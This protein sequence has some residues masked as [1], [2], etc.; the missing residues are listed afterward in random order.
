MF[1]PLVDVFDQSALVVVHVNSGRDVHGRN[2]HHAFLDLALAHDFF[3]LRRN[4]HVGAMRLGMKLQILCQCLHF[5]KLR[6]VTL[7]FSAAPQPRCHSQSNPRSVPSPYTLP[8]PSPSWGILS[9]SRLAP[10]ARALKSSAEAENREPGL[11][12][13]L[14]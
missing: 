13:W 9:G 2:Q 8:G 6:T 7:A 4:V 5:I 10:P 1:E 12:P 3:H 11:P 14:R